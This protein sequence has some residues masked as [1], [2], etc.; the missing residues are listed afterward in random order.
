MST[1]NLWIFNN[2]ND[3]SS[4]NA[5]VAWRNENSS[6]QSSNFSISINMIILINSWYLDSTH[7]FDFGAQVNGLC[8]PV[9]A[10]VSMSIVKPG[11]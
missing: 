5:T 8:I 7:T 1:Y 2:V 6:L 10:S 11:N 9:V 3:A 4:V